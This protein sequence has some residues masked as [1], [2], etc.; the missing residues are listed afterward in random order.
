VHVDAVRTPVGD[1]LVVD[2]VDA[3]EHPVA[4][5]G[6]VRTVEARPQPEPSAL[7]RVPGDVR[8]VDEHLRRDAAA[9]EARAAETVRLDDRDAPVAVDSSGSMLPLPAPTMIRS[10]S[11]VSARALPRVGG[12]VGG[13]GSALRWEGGDERRAETLGIALA[14]G[15]RGVIEDAD[16]PA[17]G[18]LG[19]DQRQSHADDSRLLGRG[20]LVAMA[21]IEGDPE[22]RDHAVPRGPAAHGGVGDVAQG[23]RGGAEQVADDV[24]QL[25]GEPAVRVVDAEVP[26]RGASSVLS[27]TS[28]AGR[29]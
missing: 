21:E 11:V 26:D 22:R 5:R 24:A 20:Q 28:R 14:R 8:R 7:A 9:V 4:D 3:V 23:A 25:P 27:P 18:E 19:G 15:E 13:V 29:P 10:Y 17:V 2:R 16:E 6:P 12:S 1:R